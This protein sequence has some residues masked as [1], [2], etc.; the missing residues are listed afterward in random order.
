M[1]FKKLSM[2]NQINL[3]TKQDD[4][5]KVVRKLPYKFPYT[6]LDDAGKKPKLMIEDWE[7]GQLFWNC[8]KRY[9][10]EKKACEKVREKYLD[11]FKNEVDL[12]FFLGT[13][14]VNHFRAPNPFIIF[15]TFHPTKVKQPDLFE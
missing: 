1:G 5:F 11:E 10:D 14:M 9:E 13:T 7:T 2:L 3:F 6:F 4:E 8:L 12:Y 15:E